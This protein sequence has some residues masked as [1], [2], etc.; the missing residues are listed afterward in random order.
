MVQV[1]KLL[2]MF[3]RS[4]RVRLMVVLA[5]MFFGA[6]LEALGIGLVFPFLMVLNSPAT[7]INDGALHQ[8]YQ[9]SG[10]RT[11][12]SF[13]IMCATAL[14]L[15]Y[16]IR[17]L[18]LA[19]V[20]H[21]QHSFI[22]ASQ[23]KLSHR[24]FT[25]YMRSPYT[26]HLNNNSADLIRNANSS[27]LWIFSGFMVPAATAVTEG[28]V[29]LMVAIM[30]LFIQ[31]GPTLIALG[32]L[33]SSCLVFHLTIRRKLGD[34]G[35]QKQH[36]EGRMIKHVH[37]GLGSLKETKVLGREGFFLC[38]YHA[39]T[40]AYAAAMR[41]VRTIQ[42]LPRLI[43]ECITTAGLLSVPLV[44]LAG[45][46]QSQQIMPALGLFA[47]AVIRLMPS[48]NRIVSSLTMMRYHAPAVDAVYN[49]LTALA[50]PARPLQ[51]PRTTDE[52]SNHR[53][54]FRHRVDIRGVSYR[55]PG[56]TSPALR[57]VN[58]T[59]GHGQ[60]VAI[61]G[62]SGAGKTTLLDVL[63]G[64]LSPSEGVVTVDGMD[65]HAD[66]VAWQQRIGYIP[67]PT[68]ITD[69]T[70]RRNI[71]F[72]LP[73]EQIVEED[74]W[75]ALAA[76]QLQAFVQS[77]PEELET[78]LGE[79]GARL[80]A[81]Q[82]QRIGIARALYHNPEVL[83]LDEA[84]SALDAE[85]ERDII[86]AVA[87]LSPQKTVIIVAHRLTTVEHCDLLFFMR[88]GQLAA[89]GSYDVLLE[90]STDFQAMVGAAGIHSRRLVSAHLDSTSHPFAAS[91]TDSQPSEHRS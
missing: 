42:E 62:P 6:V 39:S 52:G 72:G 13:M 59:I 9:L 41:Y 51:Q 70:I 34:I 1:K 4:D 5:L 55:Y 53:Q 82:R 23:A 84:T 68:Y 38:R 10:A 17:T 18:M 63:L 69:D 78:I 21:T 12:R 35:K 29:A 28:L 50:P 37:E 27:V 91:S 85:T 67:Q 36:E 90:T 33:A 73:D 44:L 22:F 81:G 86:Q 2:K 49:D 88:D 32:M 25:A 15:F 83:V 76:A 75:R 47:V 8:L 20:Y 57:D 58:F 87:Q 77:L 16:L 46:Q 19:L 43:L 45:G 71:A 74:V 30:L 3:D 56:S 48:L 31:P 11:V 26:F 79:N 40:H 14:V 66:I 64:L 7:A 80:S 54:P 24:L 60:A 61:I 65:I 89:R